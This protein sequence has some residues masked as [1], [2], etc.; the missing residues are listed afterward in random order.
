MGTG[1]LENSC[2]KGWLYLRHSGWRYIGHEISEMATQRS[3]QIVAG[4]GDCND[5]DSLRF[6][7]VF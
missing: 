3:V 4:C 7:P 2:S 6:D 1:L 5:A